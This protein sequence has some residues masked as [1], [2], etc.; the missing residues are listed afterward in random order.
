MEVR[1]AR[2]DV[3]LSLETPLDPG[4][5][6]DIDEETAEFII[7]AVN[8]FQTGGNE[9]PGAALAERYGERGHV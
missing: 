6:Q 2:G 9:A 7:A 4:A 1:D 3:V 5:D 8:A